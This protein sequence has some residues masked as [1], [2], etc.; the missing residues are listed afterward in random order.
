VEL[1][2]ASVSLAFFGVQALVILLPVGILL[3]LSGAWL[4]VSRHLSSIKP[5]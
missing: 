5:E 4:A 1:Y 3:G 2:G